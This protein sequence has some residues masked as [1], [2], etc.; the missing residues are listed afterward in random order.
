MG[1]PYKE[2]R[3]RKRGSR[4]RTTLVGLAIVERSW[5]NSYKTSTVLYNGGRFQ[6]FGRIYSGF[7]GEQGISGA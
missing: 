7:D 2:M 3:K 4:K 6:D 1:R 5:E